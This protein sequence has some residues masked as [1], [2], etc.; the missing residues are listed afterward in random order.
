MLA[1]EARNPVHDRIFCR[2]SELSHATAENLLLKSSLYH[3]QNR[4]REIP[5]LLSRMREVLLADV[6]RG[7]WPRIRYTQ[8]NHHYKRTLDLARLA[9][10]GPPRHILLERRPR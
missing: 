2:F 9:I 5:V 1:R 10:R 7:P 4:H 8:L 6:P 3:L